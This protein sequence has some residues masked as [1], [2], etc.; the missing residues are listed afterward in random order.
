MARKHPWTEI[1]TCTASILKTEI[2]LL[3]T[4]SARVPINDSGIIKL[5]RQV[6]SVELSGE[7]K[8]QVQAVYTGEIIKKRFFHP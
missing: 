1:T 3:D 7:L 8:V 6:A 2:L 5:S 4:R